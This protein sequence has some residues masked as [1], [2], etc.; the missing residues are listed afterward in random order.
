MIYYWTENIKLKRFTEENNA[1]EL[2][3]LCCSE[4]AIITLTVLIKHG[5]Q[6]MLKQPEKKPNTK[7]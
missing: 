3:V 6:Q 5:G 1:N 2:M 4:R 7:P